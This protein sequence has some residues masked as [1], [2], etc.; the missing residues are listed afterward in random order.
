VRIETI[1]GQRRCY[2]CGCV[3]LRGTRCLVGWPGG[4]TRATYCSQ[5]GIEELERRIRD[6]E[7]AQNGARFYINMLKDA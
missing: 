5:H 4:G 2:R 1:R 7:C 6:L 3:L